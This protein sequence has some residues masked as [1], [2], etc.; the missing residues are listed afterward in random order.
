MIRAE[1]EQPGDGLRCR[2]ETAARVP[3][4][5]RPAVK[6]LRR[7]GRGR[8]QRRGA[9]S[10]AA[11]VTLAGGIRGCH[12]LRMGQARDDRVQLSRVSESLGRAAA[13]L[14][15]NPAATTVLS[16]ACAHEVPGLAAAVAGDSVRSVTS[17]Q[18]Y[19][20]RRQRIP[21]LSATRRLPLSLGIRDVEITPEPDEMERRAIPRG[22][23]AGGPRRPRRPPRGGRPG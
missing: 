6:R 15:I 14:A 11:I 13:A 2:S 7:V 18:T 23:R 8:G 10:S 16:S 9:M 4:S 19:E 17:A 21:V 20:R 5:S 22:A 1:A 3:R 12:R